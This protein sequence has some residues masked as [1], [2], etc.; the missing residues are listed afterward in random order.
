[1]ALHQLLI[2][3]PI[4]FHCQRV[5]D[6]RLTGDTDFRYR[7]MKNAGVFKITILLKKGFQIVVHNLIMV[8]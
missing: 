3:E 4:V 7:I 5:S 1:M 6:T 8:N 2:E